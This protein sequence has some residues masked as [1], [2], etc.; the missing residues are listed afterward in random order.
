MKYWMRMNL[1]EI[2]K[3]LHKIPE[4]GFLEFKTTK[5]IISVL[6]KYSELEI[7]EFEPTGCLAIYRKNP[8]KFKL[9]RSDIDALAINEQTNCDFRSE[10]QGRMHACGHDVHMTVLLGL[11]DKIITEKIEANYLFL[12]QPAEEGL[13][14]MRKILGTG[15]L[16]KFDINEAYAL[17]VSGN[18][19]TGTVASKPG[20]FFGIP[21]EF[22]IEIKGKGS[23]AAFPQS[24]ND[25]VSAACFLIN[26]VQVMLKK[27]FS[28][29]DPVICHFGQINGG[30]AQNS[31]AESVQIKGTTRA[32]AKDVSFEI[33]AILFNC[34]KSA[35]LMYGVKTKIIFTS[36]FDPVVNSEHLYKKLKKILP[37]KYNFEEAETVMTG[38]DFGFLCEKFNSLLY[39]LGVGTESGDL[40]AST[41][42]PDEEAVNVGVDVMF[43]LAVQNEY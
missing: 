13:G 21:R 32:L 35:E 40:H 37:E 10:H 3:K 25:A 19:P 27:K 11:I 15:I 6:K 8:G 14:G 22:E 1:F 23:H 41:F 33:N 20:I 43:R 34:L 24:G 17:H 26:Q 18:Y 12:F 4:L 9:F 5:F 28:A 39:W 7:V 31:V 16:D 2:R 38:E 30:T 29:T 42:L 36:Y